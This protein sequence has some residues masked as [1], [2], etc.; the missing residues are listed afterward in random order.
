MSEMLTAYGTT[1]SYRD[2]TADP[3]CRVGYSELK[4]RVIQGMTPE[5]ALITPPNKGIHESRFIGVTWNSSRGKW[6]AQIK[7]KKQV[8]YLG[9]FDN[10]VDAARAFDAEARKLGRPTNQLN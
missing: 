5:M 8:I 9:L 7:V 3:V 1:K 10:D 2:W 6:Q 4:R